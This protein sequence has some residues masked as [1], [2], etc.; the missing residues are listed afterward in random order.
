[1]F[2]E[3]TWKGASLFPGIN[4]GQDAFFHKTTRSGT[5]HVMCFIE[6]AMGV[7]HVHS[8]FIMQKHY[9][10]S[11][12]YSM[13]NLLR[14]P[15]VRHAISRDLP[16]LIQNKFSADKPFSLFSNAKIQARTIT[17]GSGTVKNDLSLTR[18]S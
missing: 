2:I 7:L 16:L 1:L 15:I 9:Q 18:V 3:F 13:T 14:C 11:A 10:A 12:W 4:I 17:S 5:H 6:I 8:F